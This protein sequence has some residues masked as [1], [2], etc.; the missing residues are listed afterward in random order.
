MFAVVVA[1]M[2]A[3]AVSVVTSVFARR[4]GGSPEL[5]KQLAWLGYVGV[6]TV[7]WILVLAPGAALNP[8]G[9]DSVGTVLW[10][11]MV[12]MPVVGIPV[13]CVVAVLKYRLYAGLVVR[14]AGRG[15][16]ASPA[17]RGDARIVHESGRS[18]DAGPVVV[19]LVGERC[20]PLALRQDRQPLQD[21]GRRLCRHPCSSF[22]SAA[23]ITCSPAMRSARPSASTGVSVSA[24]HI[25][26]SGESRPAV[27]SAMASCMAA[28]MASRVRPSRAWPRRASSSAGMVSATTV[29]L[30]A[31][32]ARAGGLSP[33]ADWGACLTF[34]A[35]PAVAGPSA[36]APGRGV[37]RVV[38]APA[39]R[40]GQ[41]IPAMDPHDR[42]HGASCEI[43]QDRTG[44]GGRR[45]ADG[46][47]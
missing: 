1:T 9:G 16:P 39:G 13:A 20:P 47:R 46:G 4:S 43:V 30:G 2:A 15:P 10:V 11:L 14:R 45:T 17:G 38:R 24:A 8:G 21:R 25:S 40:L 5:R 6:F 28:A 27:S 29:S 18:A 26:S 33:V 7:V 35:V 22:N 31:A 37:R 32:C 23:E 3:A 36:E 34:L 44:A 41:A 19:P 42:Q 12:L